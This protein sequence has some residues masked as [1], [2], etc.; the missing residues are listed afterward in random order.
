M[1]YLDLVCCLSQLQRRSQKM[2]RTQLREVVPNHL[3]AGQILILHVLNEQRLTVGE[4]NDIG[5]FVDSS[6]SYN[7][8]MLAEGGY[9]SQERVD[10][11]KRQTLISIT[12]LGREIRTRVLQRFVAETGI[13]PAELDFVAAALQSVETALSARIARAAD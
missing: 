10:H 11:D 2:L 1:T 12:P 9:I 7:L 8:K 13:D 5:C 4:L 6:L 3:N